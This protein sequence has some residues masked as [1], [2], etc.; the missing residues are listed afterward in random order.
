[1]RLADIYEFSMPG[2]FLGVAVLGI[3][4]IVGRISK[5]AES[6]QLPGKETQVGR[7]RL[8]ARSIAKEIAKLERDAILRGGDDV[9]LRKDMFRR[10]NFAWSHELRIRATM[11]IIK[12]ERL[13]RQVRSSTTRNASPQG[14]LTDACTLLSTEIDMFESYMNLS[15]MMVVGSGQWQIMIRAMVKNA[16]TRREALLIFQRVL[17][18]DSDV[19]M[20]DVKNYHLYHDFAFE[21]LEDP[22]LTALLGRPPEESQF[23]RMSE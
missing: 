7:L 18:A 19:S 12:I 3:A 9:L 16:T 14:K 10:G 2:I 23:K 1:M 4:W 17:E 8:K 13:A 11:E 20:L 5:K 15:D 6:V 22:G 21:L